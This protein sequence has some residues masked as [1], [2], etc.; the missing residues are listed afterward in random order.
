MNTVVSNVHTCAAKVRR[1]A[2]MAG[3]NMPKRSLVAG[4]SADAGTPSNVLAVRGFI[5]RVGAVL[6]VFML[7]FS[8]LVPTAP[9]HAYDSMRI[10]THV[11][12]DG[13]KYT[14]RQ[15]PMLLSTTVNL[16]EAYALKTLLTQSKS[17]TWVQ[18]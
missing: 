4:L 5:A 15:K 6:A 8:L 12:I 18:K 16:P 13:A 2:L 14:Y 11:K 1:Q 17:I 3:L 7:A 9:A 10:W